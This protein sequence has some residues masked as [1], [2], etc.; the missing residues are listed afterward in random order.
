M[1]S[2]SLAIASFIVCG[3]FAPFSFFQNSPTILRFPLSLNSLITALYEERVKVINQLIKKG[4]EEDV[5]RV[6]QK[7]GS[8]GICRK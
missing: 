4:R 2:N 1:G 3:R 5:E 8:Q 7:T 6:E